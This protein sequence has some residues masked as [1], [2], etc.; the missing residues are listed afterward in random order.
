M[1]I[2]ST[3]PKATVIIPIYKSALSW[4]EQISLRQCCKV[5]GDHP[6]TLIKPHALSVEA[7][8]PY[9]RNFLIESFDDQYFKN[10]TGYNRLML[11]SEFYER[12]LQYEFMLIYQLDAFVFKD[13]LAQW[14][15][16][17]YDYIGAP[18]LEAPFR[19]SFFEN[20]THTWKLKKAY[21]E[22]MKQEG[23]I[24]PIDMQFTNRVGN[25]GFSL[26]RVKKFYKIC[27]QEQQMIAYYNQHNEHHFFNEDVFWS[28][29]VNRKRRKLK[30]PDYKKAVGFS[31]EFN[32]E[33]AFKLTK[34]KLPFGCH[35]WDLYSGFW[36][37]LLKNFDY[38]I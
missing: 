17:N 11:S 15:K 14:C 26:R 32:P 16:K 21:Y 6:I 22:N 13:E 35:A 8:L 19:R 36:W 7:Y 24:L 34:G 20:I 9:H 25:G 2:F 30:I 4:Y 28:L 1:S 37:E 10:I 33:Y 18:W 38:E 5:L 27:R 12:F 31:I 29:E 3:R 23:T